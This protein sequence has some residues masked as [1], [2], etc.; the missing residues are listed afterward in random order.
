MSAIT[1]LDD[2]ITPE[3][4]FTWRMALTQGTTGIVAV[5]SESQVANIEQL[6]KD[7]VAIYELCG[8]FTINSWLRTPQHNALVGGSP[9]SAHLLGAAVDLHPLYKTVDECKALIKTMMQ[10]VLFF[11]TNTTTWVHL[12]FIHNHDFIA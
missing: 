4:P 10:R 12:D 2:Q 6:A 9:H 8:P 3:L 7:L 5:P 1:Q 11:E